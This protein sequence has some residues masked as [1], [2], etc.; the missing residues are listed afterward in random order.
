MAR[1]R[2]RSRGADQPFL[3][4]IKD[5]GQEYGQER[6]S[7]SASVRAPETIVTGMGNDPTVLAMVE[8]IGPGPSGP[9]K[10]FQAARFAR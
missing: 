8:M 4:C 6:A 7:I 3:R 10:L 9:G 1:R 5:L 2:A